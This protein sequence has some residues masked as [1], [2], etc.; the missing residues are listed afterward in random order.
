MAKTSKTTASGSKS[1]FDI[2]K[3]FDGSAE[4]L[5]ESKTAVIKDYI[6]TGNYM[7]NAAM[8]GSLF[9]GIP[10]G[11]CVVFAGEPGSGK[12]Y[13][14]LSACRNA[15]KKGYT[16][17]YMDSEAA[18]DL[19]FVKRL[20]CDPTN[21]IIKQVTTISE[22][23]TFMSRTCKQILEM[24]EEDRPKIMFVLD[25]LGNLTSDKEYNDTVDGNGKRDM[26]KQQ[27]VK[28]L[29]RTNAT[30][31]GKLGYPFIVCSHIYQTLDLFS[32]TV[33]SGGC[34]LPEERIITKDGVKEIQNIIVGDSV[35]TVDG[36]FKDVIKTFVYDKP[37]IKFTFDNG[38][39]IECSEDHKFLVGD[40]PFDESNWKSA[41]DLT[42]DDFIYE[43]VSDGGEN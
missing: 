5:S 17:I 33:V 18:I 29:F 9:K 37:T 32:K 36:T 25:S 42:D 11:R 39:T 3:G 14:A 24:D 10:T 15:Q 19:D 16:P 34:L 22:V 2:V 23:S 6:N 8:T 7:L 1:I 20:G 35:L 26:T 13:L 38:T 40:D 4:V 28:A 43:L 41:K 30:N 12:S 27:E 21:F 31:L